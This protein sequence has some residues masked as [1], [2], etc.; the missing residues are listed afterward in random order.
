MVHLQ[1][2][3]RSEYPSTSGRNFCEMLRSLDSMRISQLFPR[4]GTW[5]NWQAGG[6]E[7]MLVLPSL[8]DGS[9]M[10]DEECDRLF[11][12]GKFEC[13]FP[14]FRITPVPDLPGSLSIQGDDLP[15][16]DS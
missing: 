1:V 10:T 13:L 2:L 16:I 3:S 6:Q 9:V 14:W 4:L 11:P 12:K 7:G 8:E 15:Q 5:A